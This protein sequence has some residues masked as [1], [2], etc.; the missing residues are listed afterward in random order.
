MM[1]K[2]F[3]SY[4]KS[5]YKHVSG[6]CINDNSFYSTYVYWDSINENNISEF[7]THYDCT[8]INIIKVEK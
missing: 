2:Y 8:I 1:N 4:V 7:Q 3:I 6:S 5:S